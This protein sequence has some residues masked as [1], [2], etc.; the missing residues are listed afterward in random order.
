M[1]PPD[2]Q[3]FLLLLM[4]DS[5]HFSS[6]EFIGVSLGG[7]VERHQ[8]EIISIDGVL[9]TSPSGTRHTAFTDLGAAGADPFTIQAVAGTPL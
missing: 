5:F 7:L 4:N 2:L 3:S 8:D 6:E 1:M 9:G